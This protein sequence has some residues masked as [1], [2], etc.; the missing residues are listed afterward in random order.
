[1]NETHDPQVGDYP[2]AELLQRA[3]KARRLSQAEAASRA[4]V[5]PQ[6]W[7]RIER[8]EGR[9][10]PETIAHMAQAVGV[11]TARL[12]IFRPDA[13]EILHEIE[14]GDDETEDDFEAGIQ[15]MLAKLPDEDRSI[16]EEVY[17]EYME[18]RSRQDATLKKLFVLVT[19]KR[20]TDDEP[21]RPGRRG[22][23]RR[24]AG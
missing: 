12:K 21:D 15:A 22:R 14:G 20:D 23:R 8:G 18:T 16:V 13:A 17:R 7:G 1:M 10:E 24:S 4:G 6:T 5:S 9:G 11:S 2:E 19:D 3:R